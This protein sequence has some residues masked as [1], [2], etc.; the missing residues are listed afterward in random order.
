MHAF[1]TSGSGVNLVALRA[2]PTPAI[3]SCPHQAESGHGRRQWPSRRPRPMHY[4]TK[5][6]PFPLDLP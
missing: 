4:Q 2:L 6:L 3:A 1:S 5:A